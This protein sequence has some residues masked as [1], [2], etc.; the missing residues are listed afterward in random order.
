MT[1][2]RWRLVDLPYRIACDRCGLSIIGARAEDRRDDV[3]FVCPWHELPADMPA[4][5]WS[6]A[7]VKP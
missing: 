1:A 3:R 2:P 5:P 6:A 4:D 7:K